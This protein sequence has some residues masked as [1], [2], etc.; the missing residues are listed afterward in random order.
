M[1]P[2]R[3]RVIQANTR[4]ERR[5]YLQQKNMLFRRKALK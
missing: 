1:L 5:E 4:S 2:R 3:K